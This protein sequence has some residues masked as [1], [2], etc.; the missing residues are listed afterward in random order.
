MPEVKVKVDGVERPLSNGVTTIGRSPDNDIAFPSDANVS[1]YHAEIESRGGEFCLIDLGSSYGTTVNGARVTGERY[2]TSGDV[3]VLGGTSR[4]EFGTG[5]GAAAPEPEKQ[6]APVTGPLDPLP[7]V[8]EADAVPTAAAAAGAGEGSSKMM[9]LIAGGIACIALLFVLIAGALFFF[10]G[11]SKAGGTSGGGSGGGGIFSSFFGSACEAKASITKP[12]PGDS[13]SAPTEIELDLE[14]ADCVAK[15]IFTIDG[16]EFASSEAPFNAA[17]DPKDFPELSDGVDHTLGVILLD[18]ENNPIGENATVQLAFETRAV[19][20]P[21]P[22]PEVAQTNTQQSQPSGSGKSVTLLEVQEMSNRMVKQF[23][24]KNAYNLSNKQFLSEVQ[25]RAAEFAQEGYF[26]RAA[27]Y[28]DVINTAFVREQN[29]DAPLG[30]FLAMSRSKF[31]PA[32][33]GSDE[34]LWRM[35]T[36][37]ITANAY[38]G[39]CGSEPVSDASQNCAAKAAALYLKAIVYGV[40][41]GDP[42][43]SAAV[44]GKSP[45]DAGV[46]KS[47]LPA[48]RDDVWNAIKTPQE[49]EQLVRFFAAGIVAENPQKFGLKKDRPLSEL[50]KVTM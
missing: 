14:G 21:T 36:E 18:E 34:G 32:K 8:A 47:T 20:K 7:D 12:E 24:T 27:R 39:M 42:V 17:I 6:E 33:Q 49:R 1:R 19:T 13:I 44:F 25:K 29:I 16:N 35:N 28:K 45:Q 50:Y 26:E 38:N 4:F 40:F 43:Y 9:L 37:F 10:A 48:K 2:L 46:W 31:D 41:D 15:A 23:S 3:V 30:F 11:S 5:N 22:G